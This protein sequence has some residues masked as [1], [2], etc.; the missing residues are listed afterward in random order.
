MFFSP[1]SS[2]CFCF[3]FIWALIF[4]L[5]TLLLL[6]IDPEAGM[7]TSPRI[8]CLIIQVV[9]KLTASFQPINQPTLD[10][11][12]IVVGSL[13]YNVKRLEAVVVDFCLTSYTRDSKLTQTYQ[14][15]IA[16]IWLTQT[17]S[18]VTLGMNY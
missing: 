18:A 14:L 2:L 16:N 3:C 10:L 7:L 1:S 6:T 9:P 4:N 5:C 12:Y 11:N 17:N 13:P 15:V 8:S